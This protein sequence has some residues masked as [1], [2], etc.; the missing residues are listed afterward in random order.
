MN[1]GILFRV[2]WM[3][4]ILLFSVGAF[5]QKSHNP[6]KYNQAVRALKSD[7]IDL[8]IR[9]FTEL[10]EEAPDSSEKFLHIMRIGKSYQRKKD[11]PMART[12]ALQ[13]AAMDTTA[14]EPFLFIGKLY[15]ASGQECKEE[16]PFLG[17][18]VSW[19]SVDMWEKAKALDET[20]SEEADRLIEKY[21]IYFP[22]VDAAPQLKEGDTYKVDCWIQEETK[23]RFIK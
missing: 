1:N 13:A 7:S 22:P 5:A 14:G 3:G 10:S 23:V 19:V 17:W 6:Q 8:A 4:L 15:I 18:A 20:L 12:F 16:I 21:N 2:F 11:F 9:I